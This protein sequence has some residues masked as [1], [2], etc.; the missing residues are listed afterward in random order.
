MRYII[1]IDLGTTNCAL[2]FVD[3][4][5]APDPHTPP[6]VAAVRHPAARESGRSARRNAA[7]LV[8]LPPGP[9]GLSAA[10]WRCPGT[11]SPL[12]RRRAARA[13]TRRRERRPAGRLG[14]IVAV[15]LRASTGPRHAA[16]TAPDG[17][18]K[19]SPV[20]ASRAYLDHLREAWNCENARRAVRGPVG[21]VTVPASFDAVARE[22][23]LHAAEQA[24]Y[25][26]IVLL[27]EPQAAFYSWIER[28]P[29]WREQ[30]TR[31]RSDPGRRYRRRH[32]RLHADRSHAG[33]RRAAARARR[34]RRAHP[35]RRRQH[36]PRARPRRSRRSLQAK[37]TKLDAMQLNALWQQC[38]VAKEKLLDPA[39]EANEQPVTILGRGT[40]LVGGTIKAKLTARQV[41]R[42]RCWT[43]SSRRSRVRTCRSPGG[44]SDCR[45]SACR[46][47]PMR[48]SR[49]TWRSSCG[50]RPRAAE[51]GSCAAAERARCP[52]HVLF[53]GG[54]LRAG[55]VRER[56][57]DVAQ[58][59][60]RGGRHASR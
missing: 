53:N 58:Q 36:G 41:H 40:G 30:V 6:P 25:K 33:R 52:T 9:D 7:A 18:G 17:V 49:G 56:I 21:P 45:R 22:L 29:H 13:E 47:P 10:R 23:T 39:Y 27:E 54:V 50:S 59:L 2:S 46:T 28:N 20:A 15:A 43:A 57:I 37:G 48:R 55:L 16:V 24:G 51:S 31:R 38:R 26:N 34:G 4:A 3:T 44:A 5:A 35:A 11:R 19:I 14:Q 42:A 32:H 60:A 8:P 12:V 1:G